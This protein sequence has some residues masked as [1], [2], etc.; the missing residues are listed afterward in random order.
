MANLSEDR[1]E[2][3]PPCG[4]DCFGPFIVKNGRRE[5]KHY[6]LLLTCF[7]SRAVHI[8]MLDDMSTDAFIN[9]LHCFGSVRG[10]EDLSDVT[11]EQT[12]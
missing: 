5:I 10:L 3:A 7:S 1:I 11:E 12:L 9:D 6:G 2:A 4:M 8:E